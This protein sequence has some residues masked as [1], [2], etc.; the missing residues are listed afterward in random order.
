MTRK[1]RSRMR[2]VE[3]GFKSLT[4]VFKVANGG[5][6]NK[7]LPLSKIALKKKKPKYIFIHQEEGVLVKIPKESAFM[8]ANSVS[9]SDGKIKRYWQNGRPI[10]NVILNIFY[11][12]I[13]CNQLGKKISANVEVITKKMPDGR[14][15]TMLNVYHTPNVR[16]VTVLKFSEKRG[17]GFKIIG[18]NKEIEFRKRSTRFQKTG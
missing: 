6:N 4:K 18:T 1:K 5:K 9:L 14:E 3:G 17:V 13:N 12:G 7:S 15:F 11:Y 2:R 8:T 10:Q 16:P